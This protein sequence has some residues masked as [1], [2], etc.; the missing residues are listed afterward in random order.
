MKAKAII[1]LPVETKSGQKLGRVVDFEID[2]L[3]GKITDYYVKSVNVIEGLFQ[4]ELIINQ[5]QV[6]SIDKKKMMVEDGAVEL[7][8]GIKLSPEAA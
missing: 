4:K 8:A 5:S 6:I 3:T 2:P 7:K 1:N